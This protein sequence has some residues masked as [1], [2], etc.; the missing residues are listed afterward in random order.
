[1]KKLVYTIFGLT[2][3]I[4][5]SYYIIIGFLVK[6]VVTNRKEISKEIGSFLKDIQEG[7]NEGIQ[8]TIKKDTIL[9]K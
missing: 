9:T 2:F 4:I 7:Y 5:I 6:E 1:M 8:D 3:F